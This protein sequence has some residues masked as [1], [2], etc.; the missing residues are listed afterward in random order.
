MNQAICTLNS[1]DA[2]V[3]DDSDLN[4]ALRSVQMYL[5]SLGF[6]RNKRSGSI[7][8]NPD[9]ILCRNEYVRKIFANRSKNPGDPMVEVYTDEGYK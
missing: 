8:I 7:R 1:N 5:K 2:R 9:H 4:S 3:Y 6:L